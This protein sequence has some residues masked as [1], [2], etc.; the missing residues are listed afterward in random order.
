MLYPNLRILTYLLCICSLFL[1][2]PQHKFIPGCRA[3]PRH[4]KN[5]FAQFYQN[6][7]K[8]SRVCPGFPRFAV[9]MP[10]P[11]ETCQAIY[12]HQL[13]KK[14]LTI[15]SELHYNRRALFANFIPGLAQIVLDI[16]RLCAYN[17]RVGTGSTKDLRNI[18]KF[19]PHPQKRLDI[20]R[21]CTYS[22]AGNTIE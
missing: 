20:R 16:P 21:F 13:C 22:G 11:A 7:P 12:F 17:T 8:L 19:C 5:F 2:Y 14:Y 9:I 3:R 4:V 18:K 1:P 6:Y 15:G 10:S